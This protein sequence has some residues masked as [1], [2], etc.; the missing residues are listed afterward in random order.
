MSHIY[1]TIIIGATPQGLALAEQLASPK[2]NVALISRNFS[3]KTKK[4]TLANIDTVEGQA[5][6]LSFSHGLFGVSLKDG[7]SIFGCNIVFATGTVPKTINLKGNGIY[8]KAIDVI[9]KHKSRQA[10][11]YGDT[12]LAVKYAI[13]LAKQF[14]Y[15]YLCTP[16]FDLN[17]S[18][19]LVRKL[20]DTAN[21]AHLPG[22]NIKTCK[23][24]L[25]TY[26]LVEVTLDTYDTIK[27][28]ALVVDVGRTPDLPAF[29]DRFIN[30]DEDGYAIVSNLESTKVPGVFAV[31][32]LTRK[33]TKKDLQQLCERLK[34]KFN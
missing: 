11:V 5:I 14:C 24:D 13:E 8:Y 12:E 19:K 1:E 6:F 7:G 29:A 30:R 17:C 9:G 20:N 32:D 26:S 27:A 28:S 21:I 22:C 33:C 18:K 23:R 34:A 4:Q 15:V 10:V 2:R 3:Y 16:G 25:K 31:G